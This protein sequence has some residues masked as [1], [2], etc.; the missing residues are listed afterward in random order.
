MVGVNDTDLQLPFT[1]V[2][3][4][5]QCVMVEMMAKDLK[6]KLGDMTMYPI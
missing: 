1:G 6:Q 2:K 4:V 5:T 3:V